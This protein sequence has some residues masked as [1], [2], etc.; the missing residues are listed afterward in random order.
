M[1]VNTTDYYPSTFFLNYFSYPVVLHQKM[2]GVKISNIVKRSIS[3]SPTVNTWAEEMAAERGFGTNFSAFIAD[4]VRRAQEKDAA[5]ALKETPPPYNVS[6]SP[7]ADSDSLIQTLSGEIDRPSPPAQPNRK[8]SAKA[9][10]SHAGVSYA[11]RHPPTG[12]ARKHA[13]QETKP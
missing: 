7:S 5:V 3:L 1:V 9:G 6:S 12:K 13:R 8:P 10:S 4:L 2:S 11:K